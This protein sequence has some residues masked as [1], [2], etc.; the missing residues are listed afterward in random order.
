MSRS[1]SYGLAV[2]LAAVPLVTGAFLLLLTLLFGLGLQCDESCTGEDW[3]HTGGAWQWSLYPV[4]GGIVFLAGAM[5]FISVCRSRP[6]NALVS[7]ALG[8]CVT[9]SGM[10]WSGDNWCESLGR[11]PLIVGLIACIL[12]SGV[13]AA[14]LCAPTERDAPT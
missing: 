8:A 9:F 14:L 4:L 7:L 3:Q 5:T 2:L 1:V 11:H 6:G 10:A 12:V 13:L